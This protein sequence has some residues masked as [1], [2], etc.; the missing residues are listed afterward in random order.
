MKRKMVAETATFLRQTRFGLVSMKR[1]DALVWL[2]RHKGGW[3]FI[4]VRDRIDIYERGNLAPSLVGFFGDPK[5]AAK[6]AT[7]FLTEDTHA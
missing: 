5:E 1:K 6:F 4:T 3:H 2:K 7:K